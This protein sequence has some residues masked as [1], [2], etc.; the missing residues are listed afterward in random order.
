MREKMTQ[1]LISLK[2]FSNSHEKLERMES[3]V[4]KTNEKQDNIKIEENE[5]SQ[6]ERL[7][8]EYLQSETNE[9]FQ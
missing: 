8:L 3:I 7:S 6:T 5:A 2:A 4:S 1:A 9:F